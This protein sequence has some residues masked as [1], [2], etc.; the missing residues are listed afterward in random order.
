MF[1]NKGVGRGIFL[2]LIFGLM[3]S[4][5]SFGFGLMPSS[6]SILFQGDEHKHTLHIVNGEGKD[7]DLSID[8]IGELAEFVSVKDAIFIPATSSRE[9]IQISFNLPKNHNFKPGNYEVDIVVRENSMR[10][11]Q[12]SASISLTS[13]LRITIPFEGAFLDINLF[14]PDFDVNK[15]G[16][17]IVQVKN[18]GSENA[19][20]VIPVV[21]IYSSTNTRIGSIRGTPDI[22]RAGTTVNFALPLDLDLVNGVYSAR[23]S[24]VYSGDSTDVF[25]TFRVGRPEILIDDISAMSFTIGGVAGFDIFL[26]NLW[27]EDIRGVY[28]DVQF[29]QKG[30]LLEETRTSFVDVTSMSRSRIQAYWDTKG[31]SAGIYELI[32]YLNYLDRRDAH[33]FE[34]ALNTNSIDIR[35]LGR[36]IDAPRETDSVGLLVVVIFFL[37]LLNGLLIYKFAFKKKK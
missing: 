6:T 25:K 7:L 35:G 32:I 12:I 18:T 21:D 16:N 30:E 33:S 3:L 17:F 15:G 9:S 20:N 27:S 37:V 24:V 14:S 26:E 29:R 19:L 23:A 4:S 2:I 11:G 28:A 36:V 31:M 34:I 13:T 8:V 22:V 5:M 10:E 1:F